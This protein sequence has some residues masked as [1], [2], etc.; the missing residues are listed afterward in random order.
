MRDP[1]SIYLDYP[2]RGR[3]PY[4]VMYSRFLDAIDQG[5]IAPKH[6]KADRIEELAAALSDAGLIRVAAHA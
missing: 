6:F 4:L 3:V 2:D 5:L 1:T